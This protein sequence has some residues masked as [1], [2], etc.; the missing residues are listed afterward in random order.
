MKKL[1]YILLLLGS[2]YVF[3][4]NKGMT[5]QAV[6]YAPG[7]Q[8][9]PGVNVANV[10]M[11]NRTICLQFSLL[12]ASSTV[13]YQEVVKTKTDEFGM[14]N[15]TIG[16][17]TQ[18]GGYATSFASVVWS[19]SA[20][21]SMKVA[22]DA[23]GLCNQYEEL[24]VEKLD[25]VPFAN[26][27]ITAGNVT[28][29]V[30][31]TNGGTGATTAA[32]ARTNLGIGNVD[33]TSDL[34][35]PMSTATKTYVDSQLTN[36]TIVD[37]DANTKGKV[38]LAGDLA[39]TAAAPTVPGLALKENAANKST[40]TTL[41]TSNVLFPTQNAVKT[42]VDTAIAGATIVDAD[43]NTKGKIQLAG[44]LAGTAAA[45]TVPGL[46]LKLDASLAGVPNGIAT[47]NSAG[48]IP[49]NQLPPIS[50]ASTNVVGSQA[51]MLALSNATVG[52]IAVR[53][54]LNKNFILS[55]AGPSVLANWIELL[56]P[57]APV[58]SV[59]GLTGAIQL[60]KADINLANVDNTSDAAKPISTATQNALNLKLNT[61]QVGVPNGT[62]SLNALGKIPTE[63]IPAISFSSVKVLASQAEMLAQTNALIGSV[64]IRTDVNKNYVLAQSD[65]TILANWVELLTPAPPVQ[66]VNGYVGN[67]SLTKADL[68]LG[69]VDNTG[70]INKPVSTPT[71]NA[72][73]LKANL[74]SPSFTGTVSGITKSMVGL[75]N[76]DNTTDLNK[77]VSTATQ[78]ALDLKAN[79]VDLT[80]ET[81]RATAAEATLTTNVATNATAIAAETTR[82]TAAEATLTT[83]VATNATAIAAETTRAT[84]AEATLT[85]NV[86][87][88]TTAIAAET[89]RATAAET[90][91]TTNLAAE[92]TRATA[93]EALKA[94]ATDVT[95]SLA[96]KANLA[97]PTFTGTPTAPTP[98]TADNSTTI[99]TTE[100]VKNSIVAANAGLS[101]IGAISTTSDPKGAII[102]GTTELVLTPADA[103]NGG[104]VTTG[105]QTFAGA[106]TFNSD[107]KVNDITVGGGS[108]TYGNTALGYLTLASNQPASYN[109]GSWN[110]AI[111]HSAMYRNTN[112]NYNTAIGKSAL[113][114]NTTGKYNTAIGYYA[115]SSLYTVSSTFPTDNTLIGT[116]SG[117]GITTG[118]FNTIIG[119]QTYNVVNGT[120]VGIGITTGSN[121]TII[122]SKILGLSPTLS[123]NVILADGSGNIRAQH[124]G[125]NGWTLGTISSGTWNG[126]EIAIAKG[127]TGATTA[128]AA[129]T[130]L[131]AEP[132]AN[133]STATDLGNTAPSDQL[134]PSQKAVKAYV[135]AQTAAAGVS[136][137]SITSAK[138]LD[139]TIAAID[140]ADN[141]ITGAKLNSDLYAAGKKFT[142]QDLLIGAGT[143]FGKISTDGTKHI[144]FEPTYNVESTRFWGNGNITIQTGGTF[145]DN[146]YKLEV[147]GTTKFGGNATIAGTVTASSGIT[148]TQFTSTI[149]DGTAP[150]VVTSTTPV[151]NL[152]IGGNAATVT[153]NA[154]LTGDVTSSGNATTIGAN[155]V[156]TAMIANATITNA[157]L[158]KANIPL[159]GFGAAAADVALGANK[160]TG[161][162]DPTLAQ[163]AAT[164][165]YV[166]TATAGITTLAEGKIYLGNASN[167]ATE[168]TPSG[169]VTITN[170]GVTAIGTG[171][172]VVG[173]LATD[174]VE[175]IK[176]KDANVTEAKLAA[177]AVTSAK[178]LNGTIVVADLAAN[179]VEEAKIKDANVTTAKLA[180]AAVTTAKITD[181]NITTA[182]LAD[183]AVTTAK[184]TDANVTYAKIQN[185]S[186]TDKV[187]G[188][189]T[190][191]AG[192]VEEIATTGSGNVVRATSPTLVTPVLGAATATTIN[193]VTITPPTTSATLTIADGKTL[194]A[195]NSIVVAGTDA[196]TMT[197]PTTDATIA[198]TDAAQTFTGVQTFSSDMVVNS[199][200][201]GRGKGAVATNTAV[202][203][204]A[205]SATATGTENAALGY[206][207]LKVVTSGS[208]NTAIGSQA[209]KSVTSGSNNTALGYQALRDNTT[210]E[211]NTAIG[212]E[213]LAALNSSA[214]PNDR[215]T[216]IGAASFLNLTSG[217]FNV[218]VGQGS[219]LYATS[220]SSNIAI[221]RYAGET[222]SASS[223]VT[224]SN[225]SIFIG[226]NTK[227]LSATSE[228]EIIIGDRA[229]GLGDN[230][231]VLGNSSS[232]QAKIFGALDLP[233]ATTSTSTTTGALKVGGGVGIVENLNVGG[234]AKITGTL[235]VTN[236]AG[237]GKVLT[238][239]ANGLGTW[240]TPTGVTTMAAIGSA[241]NANGAT[242][243][244]ANLNLEPASATYGGVVTTGAQ[245]FAGA[246]TF[247]PTLTA[248][249]N[250]ETLVGLDINPTFT[251]GSYTGLTNYGLRVQGIGIGLGSGGITTNTAVGTGV[252][253]NN[254]NG[255]NNTGLG[256]LTMVANT[257]G[258]ENTGIGTN[259][260]NRTSTGSNNTAIGSNSGDKLTTGAKNIFVGSLAGSKIATG[261][262][263]NTTGAN[264][265]LIGYDVRP[266]ADGQT[267][268]I[269]ISGYN[270]TAG[271]VGLGSNT[272]LIGSST[273]TDTRIMG[274]LD[275]PNATSSTTTT[276]GALKVAG[277][278][279]IVENLNVGGNTKI[280][281]TLTVTNGAGAGK[282][283]TSDANG[284]GTWTT[285]NA[286]PY[287]GATGAVNLGSYDLTVNGLTVG[288]GT[289]G[290]SVNN[291]NTSFGSS[292]LSGNNSGTGANTAI[293]FYTLKTNTT[294][295]SNTAI[296]F[297]ALNANSTG[298]H[299]T[300]VGNNSLLVNT[301][302]HNTAVGS[303]SLS[304]N[305][306]GI[307]NVAFGPYANQTNSTGNYNAALGYGALSASTSASENI[308][309]GFTAGSEITTGDK[310]IFIGSQ[311]GNYVGSAG[312]TKNTTGKNSVLIGYDVRPDAN[313]DENEIVISGYN[314]STPTV[315]IGSNTTLI[316]STKTQKSQLYGALTVVPNAAASSTN[317]N[318]STIAAQNA[319]TGGTNAGGSVNITAG[320][321]NNTGLGGNIVLT[322][323]TSTTAAN[324]GIVTVNGQ[325]KIADGTQGA[326]K[327]LTSD[328]AGLASWTYGSS[329]V[330]KP[331]ATATILISDKYVFYDGTADGTLTLP[332]A[333]GNAGK[334]IIIK[335]RTTKVV[336]VSRT[337]SETIYV[338]TAN[339]AVTTFTIGSEASNNWVKL[340]SDGAN[341]V[342]FRA[343]F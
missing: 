280:T 285:S 248:A 322:P 136:D 334:E 207:A 105:A 13:E 291:F 158:D 16:S 102:N 123:N 114:N 38:Q 121:N 240:T 131:G 161:V 98:A 223:Q 124:D 314:N 309:V 132:T 256:Y 142:F 3:A 87:T 133:K 66:S 224:T 74:A 258:V 150:F 75:A 203:T 252:L 210:G 100:Y 313:T 181:A 73:D 261:T 148:G 260:L 236:G 320:N 40:T 167:V 242:I 336:T 269:V 103:T 188:R 293:G 6:I 342:V 57:G 41:G 227:P 143:T 94:N 92:V 44:D 34:N 202:G 93:A 155:K 69:N 298:N 96:L 253:I 247:S 179:A 83:N 180:D 286:V 340:V 330:S 2:T 316:G 233:D 329:D 262:T 141:T 43:A 162:A 120:A 263:S 229:I 171:K 169:D 107:I 303:Y 11:T 216:A 283:L 122:G 129:L 108:Q 297:Y 325:V 187:L 292:A 153:T 70:D 39:G 186:A 89:T 157:K 156:V 206:N 10:P 189:V 289:N 302:N 119:S 265:V 326:G 109:A 22:L 27:A 244:G 95:T 125:T 117:M 165:N 151:A 36:S 290:K 111:G 294:G 112:G 32:G 173:M 228:N 221:G 272:T 12:D 230:S 201:I 243:S 287:T 209:V 72:L 54:D 282:V 26:A 254:F 138:I 81:T 160:L 308:A 220:G 149:A 110:T 79:T 251:N 249:A 245:T 331:T 271:T 159:S 139:G 7:G 315:G 335:N 264:S 273:T 275:L 310:N 15:I 68:G 53:T 235:T 147:A 266:A 8:N 288:V 80:A 82:A 14:V 99:A 212:K 246:K 176:I 226:T 192:V 208:F 116:A 307:K 332:A 144:A 84:A 296:G 64:I 67:V 163:D 33:N 205:I 238:S 164:K 25:A 324:K 20:D 318:S 213:A 191:G 234:N 277:G 183:T 1:F 88:N 321:G 241:P 339:S 146:G 154:N 60:S 45:P 170:A 104:V 255:S 77:P 215:N 270:G 184:I 168:V 319:G 37:A 17:G 211:A 135:D 250:G 284:L 198:R 328:A 106:K 305:T 259:S 85:T 78:T 278:V 193:K 317:G 55:T 51:A 338:D 343:L 118:S 130:N 62:A 172:V 217:Q 327:V 178:I 218:G 311:A 204:D 232:T 301:G 199:V 279:G 29:V 76:V 337:A 90:T 267:N 323:G 49:A 333:T 166:D 18:T 145:T 128:A 341:W 91:L 268:Q 127:G 274:A 299:N 174:A 195:N 194:T 200:N 134:F 257:S 312:V 231:T 126:T 140:I 30:A 113:T 182:K 237:A 50:V 281:G 222:S 9:V 63:Q 23:T 306:S 19:A 24:S 185:V 225:K 295:A 5:Y 197:F 71:Q 21:K 86:A 56:T 47:L 42:Y 28:G 152:S 4:Q 101:T 97:S 115:G 59:N 137:G 52:S 35:K 300:A 175:T 61:N 31:L 239:D 177:D 196:T 276:T 65:P 190:A 46:A 58:Q 304:A 48:I 219:L 214:T